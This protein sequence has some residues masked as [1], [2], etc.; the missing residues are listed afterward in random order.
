MKLIKS[1]AHSADYYPRNGNVVALINAMN[2]IEWK[3]KEVPMF[4]AHVF[5]NSN[6]LE[7]VEERYC[8][9]AK[10]TK[11]YP[12]SKKGGGSV[13]QSYHGRGFLSIAWDYNYRD[14]SKDLGMRDSLLRN[15]SFVSS[16]LDIAASTAVWSWRSRV[17][18]G[19]KGKIPSFGTTTKLINGGIE[20]DGS[21]SDK[22]KHRWT[23][24]VLIS[25]KMNVSRM[26]EN[27]CYN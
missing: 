11:R 22:A 17:Y 19:R 2:T 23:L 12:I 20:C 3:P 9:S 14:A 26:S 5:H 6:G 1:M 21:R 27:G 24:Y 10:C 8:P 16:N 15:S 25:N 7:E 18:D 13:D 4:L